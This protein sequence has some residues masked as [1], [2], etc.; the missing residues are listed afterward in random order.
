LAAVAGITAEASVTC[1]IKRLT[2]RQA[3]DAALRKLI[4]QAEV[5]LLNAKT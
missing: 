3:D 4:E 2:E 1:A 5:D